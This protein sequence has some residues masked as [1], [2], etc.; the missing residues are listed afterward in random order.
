MLKN[1]HIAD[2]PNLN[3]LKLSGNHLEVAAA[4]ACIE[5]SHHSGRVILKH[6]LAGQNGLTWIQNI[7]SN[8]YIGAGFDEIPIS[9]TNEANF[10]LK[11]WLE[12]RVHIPFLHR[13]GDQSNCIQID[14]LMRRLSSNPVVGGD[15]ARPRAFDQT[16]VLAR[17]Y[18]RMR[19]AKKL[20]V[21]LNSLNTAAVPVLLSE[22]ASMWNARILIEAATLLT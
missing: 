16:G 19:I 14:H 5:A 6:S 12:H 11:N 7:A 4:F 15:A 8:C 2:L 18:K 17:K 3:A 21:V 10:D 1:T 13:I 22:S 9:V 20:M